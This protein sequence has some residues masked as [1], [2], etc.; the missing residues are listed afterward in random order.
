MSYKRV[1]E[2]NG[3][4]Y[5]PYRYESYRDIMIISKFGVGGQLKEWESLFRRLER[6]LK[7]RKVNWCFKIK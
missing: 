2:R 1:V 7:M 4:K 6:G 3:K 5:G